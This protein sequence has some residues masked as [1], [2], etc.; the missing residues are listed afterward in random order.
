[1]EKCVDPR[2]ARRLAVTA[3]S[4][5]RAAGLGGGSRRRSLRSRAP[6]PGVFLA[7]CAVCQSARHKMC[8][9]GDI[10]SPQIPRARVHPGL[11][12][13]GRGGRAGERCRLEG[14]AGWRPRRRSGGSALSPPGGWALSLGSAPRSGPRLR[15]S[16]PG[17]PCHS[18]PHRTPPRPTP[19][20]AARDCNTL[21]GGLRAQRSRSSRNRSISKMEVE[22][23]VVGS[24]LT[25]FQW[26]C[27]TM[28][29]SQ[30]KSAVKLTKGRG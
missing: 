19:R 22:E 21:G 30:G 15:C 25:Q 29:S 5:G 11:Q 26:R 16:A 17:G 18:P 6:G 4:A 24:L 20:G 23:S 12:R 13:A 14:R 8:F 10:S 27:F 1:M 3:P 28:F 7:F 9:H 2:A